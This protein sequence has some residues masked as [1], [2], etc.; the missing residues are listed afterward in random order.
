MTNL[1]RYRAVLSTVASIALCAAAQA[2]DRR[3]VAVPVAPGQVCARLVPSS[4]NDTVRLQDAIDHCPAGAAVYLA[5]GGFRSGPLEMKS[6]VTLWIERNATLFAIPEPTAYDKG[7]GT[8]GT[9]DDKGDGCR[10]FISFSKTYGGGIY[11]DGIID[12]LGGAYIVGTGPWWRLA[13]RAQTDGGHLNAPRLIQIDDAKDITFHGITLRNAPNF[14]VAMNRVEGAIFWGVT[15]DAPASTRNTGG[16]DVGASQDVTITHSFIRTGDDNV[17]IK[18]GNSGPTR[19]VSIIDNCFGWGHGMS[20]GS[21]VSSGVS[22]ILV[23]GLTL[24]GTTSGLLIKSDVSRGGLVE[25]V[26]YENVRLRGSNRWPIIFDTRYDPH[27]EGHSIP[28]Y[29]QIVLRHVRGNDGTL[30]IR[31]LD[32]DHALEITLDDV[33]FADNATWQVE[34]ADVTVGS[35]GVSPPLP[36]RA[37]GPVPSAPSR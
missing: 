37:R 3:T 13:F 31:G 25:K 18:A 27:A 33:R 17:T 23:R 26:T 29:H 35:S 1:F 11:G 4:K 5:S 10:P 9:I 16:I 24:D 7:L 30:V 20:I 21:D 6:G 19:Y 15:I 8:C 28:A 2:Q 12:G 32:Q 14:H 36:D 22:D 34:N